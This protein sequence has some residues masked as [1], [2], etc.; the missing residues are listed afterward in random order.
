MLL[1][2]CLE[3]TDVNTE[4]FEPIKELETSLEEGPIH[5]AFYLIEKGYCDE[6]EHEDV[7]GVVPDDHEG[8]DLLEL[9]VAVLHLESTKEEVDEIEKRES[10]H[11]C[12]RLVVCR[13]SLRT[14]VVDEN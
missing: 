13:W 4:E 12:L 10:H 8:I 7:I 6:D 2:F 5:D 9:L 14:P 3:R 11:S 1:H